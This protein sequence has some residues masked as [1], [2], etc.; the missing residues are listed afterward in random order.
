MSKGA[1]SRAAAAYS[2]QQVLQYQRSLNQALPEAVSKFNLSAEDKGFAQAMA[3]GV[4]REL[5]SLEW[6]V[7]QLLDKPLKN[8]VRVVHYLLLVGLYQL[9]AM[10]TAKHAAVS[11]TVDATS[12]LRQKALKSLVNAILRAFQRQQE[13]LAHQLQQAG[14]KSLNHPGWLLKR[15]R[16]AYPEQWQ[17]IIAAN[18]SQPPMW[19]RANRRYLASQ[20]LSLSDY[21]QQL[22]EH[23]ISSQ[24]IEGSNGTLDH[25]LRLHQATDV[26]TLPGFDKGAVSV[27]DAAAQFAASLLPVKPGDYILD[28]CAA[29]GGKAAHLLERYDIELDALDIEPLRLAR[30]DENLQ[31]LQLSARLLE[32]DASVQDW[33]PQRTY[34]HILLDAPCSATGVIRRHPDIKWLRQANDIAELVNL[35]SKILTNL[36]SL[37]K[38]GGCLVYATCSVLPD[39]NA[40][41]IESFRQRQSDAHLVDVAWP[42]CE[43]SS[44]Q[45][46][47]LA[48]KQASQQ[49]VF[50]PIVNS[51]VAAP[52]QCHA[53]LQI[54]PGGVGMQWLPS[55]DGHDGFYYA[56]LQKRIS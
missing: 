50:D 44:A 27:Q 56:V 9:T 35:Q 24:R 17:D 34:D 47:S 2:V 51:G 54:A 38:P 5:P 52:L 31:R 6:Y 43:S 16:K 46:V 25:A 7:A 14:D 4:L 49:A 12:L 8:K 42:I 20:G 36:W 19:L 18:Q 32:G 13:G 39:E 26:S 10:R 48:E 33:W 3:F 55:P 45:T 53:L 37:L 11:A 40:Q 28:A 1:A 22:I 15:L 23:G 30:V 29:P 41:Q 21:Q